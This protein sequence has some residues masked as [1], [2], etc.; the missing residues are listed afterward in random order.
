MDTLT[1]IRVMLHQLGYFPRSAKRLDDGTYTL[2]FDCQHPTC[3]TTLEQHLALVGLSC[4]GYACSKE[5]GWC[6][7]VCEEAFVGLK[8]TI[9]G[10]GIA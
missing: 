4:V 10:A 8:A 9:N 2:R 5:R 1:R 6:V 3:R 7:T